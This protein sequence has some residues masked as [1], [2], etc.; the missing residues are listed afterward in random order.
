LSESILISLIGGF[1]GVIFGLAL[2]LSVRILTEYRVPISALSVVVAIGVSCSVGILFGTSPAAFA[3]G[4]DPVE[5]M[6]HE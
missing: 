3:A 2:P 6:R 1:A 4:L 5:S